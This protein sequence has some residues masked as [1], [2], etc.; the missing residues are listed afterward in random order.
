MPRATT[1]APDQWPQQHGGTLQPDPLKNNMNGV[2]PSCL[3]LAIAQPCWQSIQVKRLQGGWFK[4]QV[5]CW[6]AVRLRG[7]S[8]FLWASVIPSEEWVLY[9]AIPQAGRRRGSYRPEWTGRKVGMPGGRPLPLLLCIPRSVRKFFPWTEGIL[10][11]CQ[12]RAWQV[13]V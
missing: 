7:I 9:A 2:C 6:H 8:S 10:S 3:Q 12:N 1:G 13:G 4:S 11:A 5:F